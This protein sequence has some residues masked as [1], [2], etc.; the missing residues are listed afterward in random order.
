MSGTMQGEA[1]CLMEDWGLELAQLLVCREVNFMLLSIAFFTPTCEA[2]VLSEIDFVFTVQA[3]RE[4][5]LKS[6]LDLSNVNQW[7]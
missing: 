2:D 5:I 1:A 6:L 7:H 4:L 3:R